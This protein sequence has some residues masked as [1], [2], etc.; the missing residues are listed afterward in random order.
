VLAITSPTIIGALSI[1]YGLLGVTLFVPVVAGL[2]RRQSG[3]AEAL[4]SVAAG[5]AVSL[6]LRLSGVGGPI[7]WVS[8]ELA[9]IG[10][11]AIGFSCV[12]LGR[13]R[14]VASS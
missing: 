4:A 1:F 10:A 13:P 12:A 5:I 14:H 3:T 6:G 9:G 2:H 7:G 11:A 8:P